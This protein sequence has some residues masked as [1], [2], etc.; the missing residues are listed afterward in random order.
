MPIFTRLGVAYLVEVT[1][2]P[3]S[4]S[5]LRRTLVAKVSSLSK[6]RCGATKGPGWCND[7]SPD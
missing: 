7:A 6:R 5:N 4:G 1:R 2:P 3:T